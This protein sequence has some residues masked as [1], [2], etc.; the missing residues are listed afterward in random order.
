MYG[1]QKQNGDFKT[2]QIFYGKT[3]VFDLIIRYEYEDMSIKYQHES[4]KKST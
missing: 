2:A 4:I 1:G 3:K